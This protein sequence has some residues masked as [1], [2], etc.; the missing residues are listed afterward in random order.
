MALPTI[1]F[2]KNGKKTDIR[3]VGSQDEATLRAKI[4]ELIAL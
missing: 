4:E 1:L 3:L 2:F